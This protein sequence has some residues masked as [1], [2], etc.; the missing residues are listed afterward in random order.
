MSS[1]D[2]GR[3]NAVQFSSRLLGDLFF[4]RRQPGRPGLPIMSVTVHDG[5]VPRDETDRRVDSAIPP[6]AHLLALKGDIAYNMMRMWQG[7]CGLAREDCMLSPAYVVIRP[8][9]DI[10]PEFAFRLFKSPHVIRSFHGMSRGLVDDRLRLYYGDFAT[11]EVQVPTSIEVQRRIAERFRTLDEVIQ[12]TEAVIE[13]L[14]RIKAGLLND[15][16]SNPSRSDSEGDSTEAPE[17][18]SPGWLVYALGDIAD[19]ASG[20]TLGRNVQGAGVVELPYLRVAN[21]Q[22][23]YLDLSE[24]KTVRVYRS[25]VDSWRLRPG[26][27]LMTEGGD[28]DKLGRGTVWRG[29]IDPCLHQNHIFRVRPNGERL[30]PDFLASVV[31]SHYGKQYFMKSSKQTTNLASINS[32]QLKAFPVPCPELDEQERIVR[33]LGAFDSRLCVEQDELAKL[34]LQRS[35]LL[36]DLLTGQPLDDSRL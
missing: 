24:I 2:A 4:L 1:R 7:A 12:T 18:P 14:L 11:I 15:L 28:F 25:E 20:V 10:D 17:S 32:T 23:G 34:K 35:G 22:D 3:R 6:G 33:R 21:V 29:Q 13:K 8:G 9:Q 5:L 26:D 27:V 19:I 36:Q 30:L 16:F 31:G